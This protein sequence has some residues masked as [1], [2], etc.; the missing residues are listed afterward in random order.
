M[1]YFVRAVKYFVYLVVIISLILAILVLIGAAEAD[2]STMFRNGYN[3]LWQIALIF[4]VIAAI[5]PKF[6]FITRDAIMTGTL[7]ENADRVRNYMASKEY[8]FESE[9]GN[10]LT[11]RH[12]GFISRL[13]R[14]FEDRITITLSEEGGA[15]VEGLR[16][17]AFRIAAGIESRPVDVPEE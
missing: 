12:R 8:V 15:K 10:V 7:Q 13:S 2:I 14:M 6:G 17:D 5:Y 3:A 1:K 4:A 9:N 16:K 11:Y